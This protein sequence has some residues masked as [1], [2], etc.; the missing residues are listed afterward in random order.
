MAPK[1][2]PVSKPRP[3][4][5][6]KIEALVAHLL[7]SRD[8][9]GH[10]AHQ[11]WYAKERQH[12]PGCAPDQ[13]EHHAF[14][15]ELSNDAAATG[16]QSAADCDLPLPGPGVNSKVRDV[17]ARDEEHDSHRAQNNEKSSAHVADETLLQG[18]HFAVDLRGLATPYSPSATWAPARAV[19]PGPARAWPAG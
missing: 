9:R 15:Q 6:L 4:V 10:A 18:D 16:A 19:L 17:H 11:K 3:S 8:I 13:A 7:Y 2:K 12:Q 1:I 5:K 14:G